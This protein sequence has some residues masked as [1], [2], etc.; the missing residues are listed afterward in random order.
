MIKIEKTGVMNFDGAFRGMRNPLESWES[1]D[2]TVICYNQEMGCI[3][4]V[5]LN[6]IK[7]HHSPVE[8]RVGRADLK[9]SLSLSTLG[10]DH[11]KFMRQIIVCMDITAPLYWWKEFDTYK[12]GTVANSTSTMHKLGSRPLTKEDFSWDV[13]WG[14]EDSML[15]YVNSL[16]SSWKQST[17]EDNKKLLWRRMIQN[18]PSSFNQTRTITLNYENLKNMYFARKSHKLIEWVEYC[19]WIKSLP[20]SELITS[21]RREKE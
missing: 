7:E 20:I 13:Y 12:V 17:K 10:G 15:H 21:P 5:F 1:S 4:C 9:R 2:S 19:E 16:I 8:F 6:E 14:M 3:E 11:A 18:L